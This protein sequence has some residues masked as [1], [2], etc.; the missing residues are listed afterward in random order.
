LSG[1]VSHIGRFPPVVM[2]AY[3]HQIGGLVAPEMLLTLCK[4]NN[5]LT[6]KGMESFFAYRPMGLA[7]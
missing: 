7:T 3:T 1:Q 4:E 6:L 5:I 2:V